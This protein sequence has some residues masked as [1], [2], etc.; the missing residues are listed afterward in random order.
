MTVEQLI[1]LLQREYPQAKVL[2]EKS[3]PDVRTPWDPFRA[4]FVLDPYHV[5]GNSRLGV[6]TLLCDQHDC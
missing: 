4:C 3:G 2:V 6:V 5:Q 1:E